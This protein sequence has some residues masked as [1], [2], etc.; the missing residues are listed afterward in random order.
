MRRKLGTDE[1]IA[2]IAAGQHGAVAR[3]Q[4]LQAD[5][6]GSAI[7]RRLRRR[8]LRPVYRGVYVL[9]PLTREGRWMC[10]V[11]AAGDGAVLSHLSAAALWS[12][13]SGGEI[14]D[15][16]LAHTSDLGGPIRMHRSLVAKHER[17]IKNRIP[18]TTPTRTIHDLAAVLDQDELERAHREALVL[19]LPLQLDGTRR[20]AIRE[21]LADRP[22]KKELERRFR[23]LLRRH[24]LPLPD[25]NVELPFGETDCVWPNERLIVELD[26]YD[27][28]RS[29]SAF[30]RDRQRDREAALAGWRVVRIT[31]RQ[32]R[33]DPERVAR[34]LRKLLEVPTA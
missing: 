23:R 1:L 27:V 11:L 4:L 33:E 5:I 2:R 7:D 17:T 25:T 6:A 24:R 18:V 28:H 16:T 19:R 12:I 29:R 8:L 9:G 13:R 15:V 31:W 20:P 10:A 14:P 3:R 21:L 32:L 22:T 34:D 30:E 26:G